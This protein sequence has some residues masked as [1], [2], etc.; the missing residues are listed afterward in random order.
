MRNRLSVALALGSALLPLTSLAA[1]QG[2]PAGRP[3]SETLR[4]AT[5]PKKQPVPWFSVS[6]G[7]GRESYAV[8]GSGYAPGLDAPMFTISG[9]ARVSPFFDIGLESYG[10]WSTEQG[11]ST[12]LGAFDAIVRLHPFARWLYVKGSAGLAL[13]TFG[14]PYYGYYYTYG[15]T[16]AGF[17]YGGGIG[18]VV[19]VSRGLAL[20][21]MAD[22]YF[23]SYSTRYSGTIHERIVHLGVGITFLFPH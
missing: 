21:P 19:P 11:V 1:Q 16:Y 4:E 18:L 8:S 2:H 23:Q 15:T 7:A 20:E 14:D 10:W 5:P 22:W 12:R 9:G 13:A 17:S 6:F 3:S